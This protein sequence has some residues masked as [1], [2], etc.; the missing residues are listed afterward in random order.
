MG[1]LVHSGGQL[2]TEYRRFA[3]S[4]DEGALL[5]RLARTVRTV[6]AWDSG[7]TPPIKIEAGAFLDRKKYPSPKNLPQLFRRLGI[8]NIWAPLG[9]TSRTDAEKLL[10]SL[11]DLRTS[12]AHDGQVPT[13]FGLRDFR[14]RLA[15]MKSFVAALDRS[16]ASH[17]CKKAIG[18]AAWNQAM[19]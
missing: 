5:E 8:K 19:T 14:E 18:R 15:Q 9:A 4:E 10:T 11:N 3:I 16:L 1:Y 6:A 13:N 2:G 17:F 7:S 12:I